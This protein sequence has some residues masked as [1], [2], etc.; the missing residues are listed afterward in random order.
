M[1][2]LKHKFY[3]LH[4]VMQPWKLWS[5]HLIFVVSV[6]RHAWACPECL[7]ITNYQFL[8][9]GLRYC[10]DPKKFFRWDTYLYMSLFLSVCLS[11]S[12]S[13]SICHT[14]YLRNLTSSDQNIWYTCVKWW[15]LQVYFS[16]CKNFDFWTVRRV[17]GQSKSEK[18][19][20]HSSRTLSQ[21]QYSIWS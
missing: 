8:Q 20:L 2:H 1:N 15:Y 16:F 10:R 19:Q 5:H 4:S 11:V 9:L 17:K 12:L 6:V 13:L 21:E 18:Q 7:E 14:S 3:V